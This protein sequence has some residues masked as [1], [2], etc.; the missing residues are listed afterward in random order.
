MIRDGVVVA[1]DDAVTRRLLINALDRSGFRAFGCDSGS[2]ALDALISGDAQYVVT[3][4]EMPGMDGLELCRAIRESNLTR[5]VYVLMLTSHSSPGDAIRGLEAGA[6][7]FVTKP[8]NP[9][10]IVTRLNAGRR[11]VTLDSA[12]MTIFAMAKLAESRDPETGEH[13]ERVRGYCRTLAEQLRRDSEYADQIDEYFVNLIYQT[14]PLHDIGKV[15]IPDC[16]LL[17]QGQLDSREYAMMKDH[18]TMGASTLEAAMQ[19]YPNA[20]F[21]T[22]AHDIAI[23]HHEK[24]N[25]TGYPRGL[26]GDAIPLAGRIMAVADVY[27]ALTSK[28]VYKDAFAHKVA[29]EIMVKDRGEHFDPVVLDAFI[30]REDDFVA[31]RESF[32]DG[33]GRA[34]EDR[35]GDRVEERLVAA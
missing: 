24:W 28:R 10:E 35:P 33:S 20:R 2:E 6:D 11:L 4:W 19:R 13:L 17:K 30:A 15:A 29:R 34:T 14:S 26:A 23:S 16:V 5:Y 27:D 25:G 18:A 21:L 32:V 22:M 12:E 9:I 3:D 1:D 8:F 31:I 7:D